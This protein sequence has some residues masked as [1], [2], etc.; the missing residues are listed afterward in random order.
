MRLVPALRR[1]EVPFLEG[2]TTS[3]FDEESTVGP[4]VGEP[5]RL[6]VVVG[7]PFPFFLKKGTVTS[8]VAMAEI[9]K[10]INVRLTNDK[11]YIKSAYVIKEAIWQI[12]RSSN[13]LRT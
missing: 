10:Q 3:D 7:R 6:R 13:F 1:L 8:V 11:T 9:M 2:T 5:E 12:C 4:P